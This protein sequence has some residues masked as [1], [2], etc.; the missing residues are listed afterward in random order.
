MLGSIKYGTSVLDTRLRSF[1]V[2]LALKHING[3]LAAEHLG[4]AVRA[5]LP[6]QDTDAI[7]DA[8]RQVLA[9][10]APLLD[11]F[12]TSHTRAARRPSTRGWSSTTA[13]RNPAG[14]A[15]GRVVGGGRHR[16][17]ARRPPGRSGAP[18]LGGHR[19]RASRL[20]LSAHRISGAWSGSRA[21]AIARSRVDRW[22]QS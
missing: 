19:L 8:M 17:A 4:L 16:A 5:M 1:L 9:D 22:R 15:R 14:G 6:S 11:P 10:G 20:T 18:P 3:L 13:R 21:T 7:E 2:N 12:A